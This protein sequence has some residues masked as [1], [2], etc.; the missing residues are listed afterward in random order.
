[1]Y[2]RKFS[3]YGAKHAMKFSLFDRTNGPF[4][5]QYI[6]PNTSNLLVD[7][8]F[9]LM[10]TNQSQNQNENKTWIPFWLEVPGQ[11]AERPR[12]GM[13]KVYRKKFACTGAVLCVN[14]HLNWRRKKAHKTCSENGNNVEEM[15]RF[16][17]GFFFFRLPLNVFFQSF[18]IFFI[19]TV[20]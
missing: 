5:W 9:L 16:S 15:V 10:H 7:F 2:W 20:R 6:D 12:Y 17:S 18:T 13:N 11:W 1:M 19:S 4:E 8:S 14:A 3:R